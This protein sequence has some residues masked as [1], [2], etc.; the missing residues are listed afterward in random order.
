LN[1]LDFSNMCWCTP[2]IWHGSPSS[3]KVYFVWHVIHP[4]LRTCLVHLVISCT[5]KFMYAKRMSLMITWYHY[6]FYV[7]MV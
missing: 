7:S 5:S 2:M 1:I 4:M 6:C 3:P